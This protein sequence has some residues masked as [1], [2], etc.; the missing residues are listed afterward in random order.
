MKNNK[1]ITLIALIITI[2]ILLILAAVSWNA[3]IGPNGLINRI[4]GGKA[5]HEIAEADQG[6]K[7]EGT[8]DV[9]NSI[10]DNRNGGGSGST[11]TWDND[12]PV[13]KGFT[14]KEG[15][16]E[17][18]YVIQDG[19][20]NE[21]VWI[22]VPNINDI[23][24]STNKAGKLWDFADDGATQTA[25]EF[26]GWNTGARREPDVVTGNSTGDGT[27]YDGDNANLSQLGFVN[28]LSMK[29]ELQ[30]E[31]QAMIASVTKYK[32]FY[33]GRYETGD[34]S[35]SKI[36]SKRGNKDIA[37]QTWYTMYKKQKE[38]YNSSS[39]SVVSGMIWGC[40]WDRMLKVIYA[41]DNTKSLTD[42]KSWG[43]Y[44]N[45]EFEYIE[46]SITKTKVV[47]SRT[48]I[49]TGGSEYAKAY[50]IYDVAGNQYEWTLQASYSQWRAFR[51]GIYD[52]NS[53][54]GGNSASGSSGPIVSYPT[55][56]SWAL[57][58]RLQL[59]IK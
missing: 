38:L 52:L 32:G 22:P 2:I 18:G 19:D 42:S 10:Y 27:S 57:G 30:N 4:Q 16:K 24:D 21:F 14:H 1:G 8:A 12:V 56:S 58:T 46:D 39:D 11:V 35:K 53:N 23:Y 26:P 45:A 36:V 15:T 9:L 55:L 25:M 43:N 59:Y 44:L 20:G 29:T 40:Q 28:T 6:E 41:S 51:G 54:S 31:F 49:P 37:S 5:A 7:L 50:N 33:V 3:I 34:L 47:G 17:E 13:P 48:M